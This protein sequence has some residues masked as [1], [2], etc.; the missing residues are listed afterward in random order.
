MN[1]E[2][3]I[4]IRDSHLP[5]QGEQFDCLAFARSV[6]NAQQKPVLQ[7]KLMHRLAVLTGVADALC[8]QFSLAGIAA[9]VGSMN[10]AEDLHGRAVM[11]LNAAVLTGS[12]RDY[13]LR[14]ARA[15]DCIGL[16]ESDNEAD[17]LRAV[18]R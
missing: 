18:A 7:A 8:K 6:L 11:A 14:T 13:F 1:D 17:D 9:K 15:L 4:A 3:L 12:Q 5:S 2:D 16:V 10:P